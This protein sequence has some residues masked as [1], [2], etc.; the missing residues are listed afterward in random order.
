MMDG[1]YKSKAS[2]DCKR[3]TVLSDCSADLNRWDFVNSP[4][5]SLRGKY[6]QETIKLKNTREKGCDGNLWPVFCSTSEWGLLKSWGGQVD[7]AMPGM[8]ELMFLPIADVCWGWAE[9]PGQLL[10]LCR[11]LEALL[12]VCGLREIIFN[13]WSG[14][15]SEE[16]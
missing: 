12:G 4:Q 8:D 9:L 16:F 14:F 7:S 10:C 13:N 1:K 6:D 11:R 3:E 2:P 5:Y 15:V